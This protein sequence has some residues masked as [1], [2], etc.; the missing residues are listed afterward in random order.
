[1]K[2]DLLSFKQALEILQD[3][4]ISRLMNYADVYP[5]EVIEYAQDVVREHLSANKTN[6]NEESI[7]LLI[8]ERHKPTPIPATLKNAVELR[9]L[10]EE[11][12]RLKE[13]AKTKKEPTMKQLL[14]QRR[15]E[16]GRGSD[17]EHEAALANNIGKALMKGLMKDGIEPVIVNSSHNGINCTAMQQMMEERRRH[18]I[19]TPTDNTTTF[20]KNSYQ[21]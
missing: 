4:T 17:E 6:V 19:A 1:M 5:I 12:D 21:E 13:N 7:K 2:Y 18:G 20:S 10:E 3:V 16:V 15:A 11:R 14:A 8:R 9:K